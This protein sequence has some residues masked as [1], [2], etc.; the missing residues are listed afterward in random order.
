MKIINWLGNSDHWSNFIVPSIV[1]MWL[2]F[3]YFN[4]RYNF[5]RNRKSEIYQALIASAEE[6]H[7]SYYEGMPTSKN[8]RVLAGWKKDADG[9]IRPTNWIP[10]PRYV[11]AAK[12]MNLALAGVA[13]F[14][15]QELSEAC[16]D[17]ENIARKQSTDTDREI[18]MNEIVNLMRRDLRTRWRYKEVNLEWV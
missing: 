10:S 11:S 5:N 13:L 3:K 1:A 14:G 16:F 18:K 4:D 6:I 2:V 17:L 15:T 8:T 9:W 7:E 12:E